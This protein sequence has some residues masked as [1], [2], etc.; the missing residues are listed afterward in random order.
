MRILITTRFCNDSHMDE[1][2]VGRRGRKRHRAGFNNQALLDIR[3]P[4][5]NVLFGEKV[6]LADAFRK[7]RLDRFRLK[8]YHGLPGP[9]SSLYHA[10]HTWRTYFLPGIELNFQVEIPGFAA[11]RRSA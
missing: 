9:F 3:G 6:E 10:P 5:R 7:D 4:H 8:A 2:H 1:W 11:G